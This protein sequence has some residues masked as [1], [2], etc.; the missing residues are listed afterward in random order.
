MTDADF[1]PTS[2][3]ETEEAVR[4]ALAEETPL[5]VEGLGTKTALGRPVE[6]ER[7][8][9]LAAMNRI[10]LYE[11][12]ELVLSAEPGVPLTDI[13]ALLAENGQMLAF[14]PPDFSALLGGA[15][16]GSLGGAIAAGLSG[17]RRFHAGAARD[18]VLGVEGVSGRGEAFK[19]GG[20]V[21]KNVTGYDLSKLMTGSFGGLAALT[22]IT[23]KVAPKPQTEAS[24][25]ALDLP[26]EAAAKALRRAAASPFVPTGLS[27]ASTAPHR[28][29]AIFRL[30]G[31]ERSVGYRAD[32]LQTLLRDLNTVLWDEAASKA[33]WRKVRDVSAFFPDPP[34]PL[35]KLVV[36]PSDCA[37]TIDANAS[38]RFL[39]D[40]AGGLIWL[41]GRD[42]GVP[43]KAPGGGAYLI[44]GS[45]DLRSQTDVFPAQAGALRT[46]TARVKKGF[47]PLGLLN[48]G[49]MYAGL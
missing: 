35:W 28:A 47:D 6:A 32:A 19:S 13:E 22:E 2:L 16:A 15:H 10:T 33:H 14:E 24:L 29:D 7:T 21:V 38:E 3:K 20:R 44:R 4:A 30:E 45:A 25:A 41:E 31:S 36:A 11:P 40:W 43:P 5:C 42:D 46:L 26:L 1:A 48:P 49:R 18:F 39:A 8:L 23:L 9:S 27:L 12:E 17:P 37:H 34:R